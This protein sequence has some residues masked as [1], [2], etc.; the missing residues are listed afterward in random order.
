MR[1]AGDPTGRGAG[2]EVGMGAVI[3]KDS[4]RLPYPY[5]EASRDE[6]ALA[7]IL[8]ALHYHSGVPLD[9]VR[10]EVRGGRCVLSGVVTREYERTLA[11]ST[12]VATGGVREVTNMISL[13]S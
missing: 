13:E 8:N 1:I 11:E 7:S 12:A 10:V 2:E 5:G 6:E 4:G 9:R 3:D